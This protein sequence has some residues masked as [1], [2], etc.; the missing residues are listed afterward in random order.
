[1]TMAARWDRS[2][3]SRKMFMAAAAVAVGA[4]R[5][6]RGWAAQEAAAPERKRRRWRDRPRRGQ[7]RG[8]T[9]GARARGAPW[10]SGARP[11]PLKGARP[12]AGSAGQ[13][14]G[15]PLQ[16]DPGLCQIFPA[17]FPASPRVPAVS[18]TFL[19]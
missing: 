11:R 14:A 10:E 16:E 18:F 1:M 5:R 15:T 7:G 2:P 4:A 17:G 3:V 9:A 12:S 8:R 19:K 6:P 13:L